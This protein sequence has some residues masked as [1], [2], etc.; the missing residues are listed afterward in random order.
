MIGTTETEVE[1]PDNPEIDKGEIEYLINT[2]NNFF[3]KQI[4]S[5]DIIDTFSGIRPLIEDFKEA[6]KVTRDYVFDLNTS[7]IMLHY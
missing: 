4:S 6:S 5:D 7:T 3:I 2:V 1:T